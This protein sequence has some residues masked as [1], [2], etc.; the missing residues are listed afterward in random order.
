MLYW[1]AV[2]FHQCV[3][4]IYLQEFVRNQEKLLKELDAFKQ[5]SDRQQESFVLMVAEKQALQSQVR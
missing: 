4:D 3:D 5:Q 2:E 1:R